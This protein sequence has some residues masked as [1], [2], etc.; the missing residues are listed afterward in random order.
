M[1]IV[2]IVEL[3]IIQLVIVIALLVM[4]DIIVESDCS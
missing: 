3:V 1:L 4:R 2:Q